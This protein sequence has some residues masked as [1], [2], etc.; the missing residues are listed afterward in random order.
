MSADILMYHSISDGPPPTC[1]PPETFA[2]QMRALDEC[3]R[4]VIALD[5]VVEALASGGDIP[6]GAVVLSFDDG[7]LDFAEHA[8]PE[9]SRRGWPATVF[10]PSD[11][12]GK[13][14]TWRG[15]LSPGRHLLTWDQVNT[16]AS[17]G[18]DFGSHSASHPDLTLL[19]DTVLNHEVE[20]PQEAIRRRTGRTPR[21][22][23][24][25]YGRSNARVRGAVRRTYASSCGT[26]LARTEPGADLFDLP[27]IEMHYFTDD[28][29]WR[30]HLDGRGGLYLSLRA[31]LRRARG[32]M[33]SVT[34]GH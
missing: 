3:G 29:T 5:H 22:F 28:R 4:P 32:A 8:W 10:L 33:G 6:E 9:L 34:F 21:H 31:A 26:T 24:P 19:D 18:V 23:A 2:R 7:F 30:R 20:A 16:L 15:G 1:I 13:R 17:E 11:H 25:P 27:R 14:E 12:M